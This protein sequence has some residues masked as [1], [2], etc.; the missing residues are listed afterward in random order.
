MLAIVL[1][2]GHGKSTLH[3]SRPSLFDAAIIAGHADEFKAA[4]KTARETGDWTEVD[5]LWRQYL[6]PFVSPE[7][8]LIMVPSAEVAEIAGLAVVLTIVLPLS[9]LIDGVSHRHPDRISNACDD[10]RKMFDRSGLLYIAQSYTDL[11]LEVEDLYRS[12][13]VNGEREQ[14]FVDI[15][16][17]RV[18][19][20]SEYLNR[21]SE[22]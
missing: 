9:V 6:R 15:A 18:V 11:Q 17:N 4:R 12:Y 21:C 20:T 14:H 10:R 1:P 7:K 16:E 2:T 8:A 5:N 19:R 3:R 13:I 22:R